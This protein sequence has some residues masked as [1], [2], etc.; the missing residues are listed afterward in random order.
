M[1]C[2]TQDAAGC[3]TPGLP[4]ADPAAAP[5]AACTARA[6]LPLLHLLRLQI[7]LSMLKRSVRKRAGFSVDQ[8]APLDCVGS[9][10]IPALFGA[11]GCWLAP[12]DGV[13]CRRRWLGCGGRLH[14]LAPKPAWT[15]CTLSFP[16]GHASDDTFV[17]K[18]HSERLFAAYAGDKVMGAGWKM[19]VG[20]WVGQRLGRA[21]TR[22]DAAVGAATD[23]S[24]PSP[25]LT[26]LFL[27]PLCRTT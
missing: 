20:L 8:V 26:P 10:Y 16:T 11:L 27:F 4:G 5:A 13:L 22:P 1:G 12:E 23:R 2:G 21:G 15:R 7:A 19:R 17:N 14:A 3:S 6:V 24:L 9:S 25:L 18:H